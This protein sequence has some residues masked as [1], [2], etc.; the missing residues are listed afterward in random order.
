MGSTHPSIA[1]LHL[2]RKSAGL[3]L[4][5]SLNRVV[6]LPA[7]LKYFTGQQQNQPQGYDAN[8][9]FAGSFS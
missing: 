1:G 7:G 8:L 3:S 2:N 6:R 9:K 5:V 4:A